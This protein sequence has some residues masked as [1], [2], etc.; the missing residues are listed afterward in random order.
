MRV[1]N[2]KARFALR[3]AGV[4]LAAG[5][6]VAAIAWAAVPASAAIVHNEQP[7]RQRVRGDVC[8]T[9]PGRLHGDGFN[10][11]YRH[12]LGNGY[13][14]RRAAGD[15][16]A[17]RASALLTD[18]QLPYTWTLDSTRWKD[19]TYSIQVYATM[20][21]GFNTASATENVTF[22][23]GITS[24][25]VNT[26]TFTPTAGQPPRQDSRWC[27]GAGDGGS[28]QTSETN[29]VHLVSSWN[30]NLFLYLGDVYENGR[31]M[32]FDN[33]Y[34]KAGVPGEY[35]QFYSISDPTIGNHEYI[36]SD[37]AG[38]E[39]Y[40]NNVPHFYSYNAGGWHFVSLD[41]IS[42]FVGSHDN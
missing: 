17:E 23:N 39:W 14:S 19:G 13:Q 34:G 36:G 32:E 18:F 40:W 26:S 16:H 24:P 38:Y 30:P 31:S 11:C 20:R 1:G 4:A 37:I 15:F 6:M 41:N 10:G 9:A 29:V 7:A 42:K 3:R 25:P 27:R 21:D 33:N 28:G 5:G 12:D 8:I 2:L 22:S 35:G